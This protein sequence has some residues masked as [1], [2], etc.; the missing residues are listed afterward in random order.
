[1]WQWVKQ[2]RRTAHS[3]GRCSLELPRHRTV[4]AAHVLVPKAGG[5]PFAEARG[6]Y[7]G[8]TNAERCRLDIRG[9]YF[10]E[11]TPAV[12][13]GLRAT[14]KPA[15]LEVLTRE[16]PEQPGV[17]PELTLL[18]GQGWTRDLLRLPPVLQSYPN[19]SIRTRRSQ[20]VFKNTRA[21][22]MLVPSHQ[23]FKGS[24][25][26]LFQPELKLAKSLP[27]L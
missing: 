17:I 19:K 10:I 16:S 22:F 27:Q 13:R 26:S 11:R 2:T 8:G 20:P 25:P 6:C 14:V 15:S 5:R 9:H 12:S 23:W 7:P 18:W 24:V 4:Q 1:M 3:A 21:Q